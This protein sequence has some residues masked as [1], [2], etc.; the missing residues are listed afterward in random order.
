MT[1]D[2]A[3]DASSPPKADQPLAGAET[4]ATTAPNKCFRLSAVSADK[5]AK[6]RL[7]PPAIVQFFAVT[8]LKNKAARKPDSRQR[9]LAINRNFVRLKAVAPTPAVA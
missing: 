9:V 2:L 8:V 5:V 1:K 6:C 4:D 7:N 3:A